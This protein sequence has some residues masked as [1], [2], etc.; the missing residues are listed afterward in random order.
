[1]QKKYIVRLSE[2]EP[3]FRTSALDYPRILPGGKSFRRRCYREVVAGRAALAT[4]VWSLRQA[5]QSSQ[6][7]LSSHAHPP[8]ASPW[9]RIAARWRARSDVVGFRH[10]KQAQYP[11]LKPAQL[12]CEDQR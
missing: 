10:S 1:M 5:V 7:L 3:T 4:R 11:T 8:G 9:S 12:C 2:S 6:R